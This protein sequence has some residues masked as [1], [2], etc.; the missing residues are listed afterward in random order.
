MRPPRVLHGLS[1]NL[2]YPPVNHSTAPLPLSFGMRSVGVPIHR[3]NTLFAEKCANYFH[4]PFAPF[5]IRRALGT[6][7]RAATGSLQEKD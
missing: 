4:S 7:V 2:S 3:N 1:R 6:E 5:W